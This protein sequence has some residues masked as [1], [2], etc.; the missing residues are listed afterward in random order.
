V[1]VLRQL[2]R[3]EVVIEITQ[4]TQQLATTNV[5]CAVCPYA[6]AAVLNREREQDQ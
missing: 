3:G 5:I 4:L 2:A 1:I 6:Q